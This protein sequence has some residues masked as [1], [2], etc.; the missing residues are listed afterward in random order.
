MGF[1]RKCC[2]KNFFV[3]EIEKKP[4]LEEEEEKTQFV[5]NVTQGQVYFPKRK[6]TD[7]D[8]PKAVNASID[9]ILPFCFFVCKPIGPRPSSSVCP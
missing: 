6:K 2:R 5:A 1:S 3:V 9:K 4:F 8:W 7:Y